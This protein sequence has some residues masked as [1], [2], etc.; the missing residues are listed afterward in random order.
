[1]E[2]DTFVAGGGGIIGLDE[3]CEAFCEDGCMDGDSF[4]TG[5]GG[6]IGVD[7]TWEEFV[8]DDEG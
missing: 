1:M 3:T 7:E 4:G 6:N 8:N 5:G 2:G